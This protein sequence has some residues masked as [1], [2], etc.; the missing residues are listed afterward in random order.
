MTRLASQTTCEAPISITDSF[1]GPTLNRCYKRKE[2]SCCERRNIIPVGP[3]NCV[4][5]LLVPGVI[6][7]ALSVRHE[8]QVRHFMINQEEQDGTF[9][10]ETHHEKSVGALIAWHRS[11][12]KP[13]SKAAPARLRRPIERPVN[14][15]YWRTFLVLGMASH[16]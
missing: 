5:S 11:N 2:I 14:V 16:S 8:G 1:H 12:K 4:Y 13:L 10:I 15:R 3:F 7:L 9:Y 6:I